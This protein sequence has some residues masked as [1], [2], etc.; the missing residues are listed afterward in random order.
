VTALSLCQTNPLGQHQVKEPTEPSGTRRNFRDS[1]KRLELRRRW[2]EACAGFLDAEESEVSD[3]LA[4]TNM[5]Q[6]G[7]ITSSAASMA[8]KLRAG[9]STRL[10]DQILD[11][12]PLDLTSSLRRFVRVLRVALAF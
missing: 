4:P 6:A 5:S 10:Q 8:R 1:S 2:S 3:P 7:G 9:R 11:G 12:R